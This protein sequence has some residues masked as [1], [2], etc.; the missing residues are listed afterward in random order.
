M[1]KLQLSMFLTNQI[2]VIKTGM[3]LTRMAKVFRQQFKQM[4]GLP[5]SA[6][7]IQVLREIRNVY[8]I[9]GIDDEFM[10]KIKKH[11][12]EDLLIALG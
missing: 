12:A 3:E 8:I 6:T 11:K 5:K 1:N 9:N 7:H 2:M 10:E 4:V